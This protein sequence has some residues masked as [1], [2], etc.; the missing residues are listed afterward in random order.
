M[1]ARRRIPAVALLLFLALAFRP[2][3]LAAADITVQGSDTLLSLAGRWAEAYMTA[4]P[5]VSIE[6]NGGG[7]G[8]GVAALLNGTADVATC[9]RRLRAREVE[10][11]VR[12]F[13][14]R[15]VEVPVALDA[16]V[17]HVHPSNSVESLSLGQLSG[18]Y[19]GRVRDWAEVGGKP[20]PITVYGRENSSGTY[21]HFKEAVLKDADYVDSVLMLQ[22]T[23]QVVGAVARDPNGIGYGT[24]SLHGGTRRLRLRTGEDDAPVEANEK[25]VRSGRYPLSRRLYL[26]VNPRRRSGS[27]EAWLDWIRGPEGQSMVSTLGCYPLAPAPVSP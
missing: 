10:S 24:G 25:E 8:T 23:S 16:I 14:A 15:P 11:C 19:R 27:V 22:G 5:G 2:V 6:V 3:D 1:E 21:E 4:H 26:Y 12:N 9:S 20:G 7:T 13:G 18:I 17:V